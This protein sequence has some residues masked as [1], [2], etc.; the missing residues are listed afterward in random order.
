MPGFKHFALPLFVLAVFGILANIQ[1]S[2]QSYGDLKK[3]YGSRWIPLP[4]P[5]SRTGPGA[6][7][8]ILKGQVA[9]ESNL[10]SCG[11]PPTVLAATSSQG[12]VLK[13]T[14][15]ADYGA[16][17]ALAIGD[18]KI[19]PEFKNVRKVTLKAENHKATGL[20]RIKLGTWFNDSRTELSDECKKFLAGNDVFIV[21]EAYEVAKGTFTFFGDKNTKMSLT[22]LKLGPVTIGANAKA[23]A[24]KDGDLEFT[25]PVFTA[26]RR[27]KYMKSGQLKTLGGP[28]GESTDDAAARATLEGTLP[29]AK[30]GR[31]GL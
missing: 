20:D 7:V 4:V 25:A 11:A 31:G 22:G 28:G 10:T 24:N 9:W 21:Q 13:F 17:A 15:N 12:G 3:L 30:K 1:T 5:D 19:G 8:T 2:A 27:L 14:A 29:P 23:Q 26:I 18:V 16:D 6:I